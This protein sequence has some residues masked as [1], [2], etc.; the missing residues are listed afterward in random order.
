MHVFIRMECYLQVT[1]GSVSGFLWYHL[2][3]FVIKITTSSRVKKSNLSNYILVQ[4]TCLVNANHH[5]A[6][7]YF[8][9]LILL[10]G[11]NNGYNLQAMAML[12]FIISN[13]H[14]RKE[15]IKVQTNLSTAATCPEQLNTCVFLM[16]NLCS[17]LFTPL[18]PWKSETRVFIVGE[19]APM[20]EYREGVRRYS[21]K[22][23]VLHSKLDHSDLVPSLNLTSRTIT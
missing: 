7:W 8:R 9:F 4:N 20:S 15:R 19:V 1:L 18:F 12:W 2:F 11:Y 13:V 21:S 23:I 10:S 17:F 5:Y 14:M 6:R 16:P 22:L 3:S